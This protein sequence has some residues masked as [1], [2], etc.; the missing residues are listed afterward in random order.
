MSLTKS[1]VMKEVIRCGKDPAYFLCNYA[2]ITEPM[3]G[4]IPFDLYPYQKD[5]IN[6]FRENRFN[7]I[8]KARQLGLSTSVAGYVCWLI[9]FHRSKNVLVVATKLQSATNLVKKIKQIHRNLP[10]WL[11]IADISINNRT[12]FELS[13]ASQVKA[14]S[15]SGDAGRSEAL[16][17]L[18]VDEAAHVE[19]LEELW[20][21][22]YPT[23]STGGAAITLSTPN[24]VGNWFH[25]TY[26]ESVEG[27][28]DFNFINLP[29]S[30]HPDRDM[31]WFE[32][33]TRNMSRREIAQELE[34]SFNASGETVVSGDSLERM[35]S[36]CNDPIH[37]AGFDRNYWIWEEPLDGEE[38]LCV[39]DVAR[40]DGK[41]YSTVQ[42]IKTSDMQQVAEY[43]GKLT[44]DMFAPLITEI[45]NEYNKAL[46][47]IEN[48]KDYGVLSRIEDLEY[49]NIYYS[50][51]STHDYVD[52]LTAQ[53]NS[54]I[55]GF[56]M[57]MKTRPLV[58]SKLEEFVRNNMLTV[59]SVRTA[60]ELKTFIWHNG[61]AQAMR[62][63]NDDLVMALAI[64]CWVRDVAMA[65]NKRDIEYNRAMLSGISTGNRQLN[66]AIP[67]MTSYRQR[68]NSTQTTDN[69]IK[70]D[71]SW[72]YKG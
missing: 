19:G 68:L 34:C 13:N 43:Q 8:L 23:L 67:G 70:Y 55:A 15:T 72:I 39:G 51:K 18:V 46:L 63:Y 37:R 10:E 5:V 2:K 3:R 56:T 29:W 58:V 7:I 24:G 16:S 64:G 53:A 65:V 61:K 25:K 21:G 60:S 48:N 4:L 47:V 36:G 52:Q 30:I 31:K 54:G 17:L 59:N 22:L 50:L 45:A 66:T 38:Y 32:K 11:K 42:V 26:M 27:K 49:D 6:E 35:F 14:S 57:S 33:E 62:G 69:G 20:A 1:E 44:G 28:N 12:S 40:G 9:L 41:D 71:I